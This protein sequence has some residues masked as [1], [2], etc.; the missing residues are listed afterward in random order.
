MRSPMNPPMLLM[1][2]PPTLP[3]NQ[4]GGYV[5]LRGRDSIPSVE[6]LPLTFFN[7]K[8]KQEN[9]DHYSLHFIL[10]VFSVR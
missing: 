10:L 1:S 7:G 2:K 9:V 6:S 4:K 8:E 3:P 5:G